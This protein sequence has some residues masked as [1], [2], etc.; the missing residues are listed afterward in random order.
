VKI[1]LDAAPEAASAHSPVEECTRD[2]HE[3]LNPEQHRAVH[4]GRGPVVLAAAAG[5]GKTTVVTLRVEQ[6][7][8]DGVDPTR[9]GAFTFGNDAAK[10]IE[11]RLHKLGVKTAKVSTIH[12]LCYEI[13]RM[14]GERWG[15]DF[16]LDEKHALHICLKEIIQRTLKAN[17]IDV[18][19]VQS[20]IGLAKA[21]GLSM[22]PDVALEYE[23]EVHKFFQ[24]H[25]KKH[26]RAGTYV[27]AYRLLEEQRITRG[28]LDFDDMLSLGALTLQKD[29]DV[30][31]NWQ[32]RFDYLIV[33]EAQDSSWIQ[34]WVAL[35]LAEPKNNI[36]LVGDCQQS[37]YRWRG[38]LP[39]EFVSFA[40]KFSVVR[41]PTNYR[42]TQEIC[43]CA[44]RLTHDQDWNVTGPTL[45]H[46]AAPSDPESAIAVEYGSPDDEAR[47]IALKIQALHEDGVRYGD[48]AILYRVTSL[49]VPVE[50]AFLKAQIPYRVWSG[51]NFYERKEV[52]DL[53][54]YLRVA[55]LRDPTEEWVKRTVNAPFRY[56]G[57][58]YVEN[59]ASFAQERGIAFL[60]ALTQFDP[61]RESQRRAASELYNIHRSANA[62]IA[63]KK[64]AAT[65]L[66]YILDASRYLGFL[67]KEEGD[68]TPDPDGGR[69]AHVHQLLR[70]AEAFPNVGVFL[71]YA[72]LMNEALKK[73]RHKRAEDVVALSSIHRFKG[74]ERKHIFGIGWVD[75]IMPH[76]AN[77]DEGEELRLAY[78]CLTRA[79]EKFEASWPRTEVS[80]RGVLEVRP[81][82]FIAKAGMPVRRQNPEQK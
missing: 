72:E 45:H 42:S 1:R 8:H 4:W 41:V 74:L 16:H 43:K 20:C 62:L 27:D 82:P 26:W 80:T 48:I 3:R 55:A 67:K 10:E 78:V 81:S 17:D 11:D 56:L 73:A 29:P 50:D 68:D 18:N 52:K 24:A 38:A 14:D 40:K 53:L 44:T 36:M 6:L 58:V 30:L 35:N 65:V 32:A 64:G 75:G 37:L 28:L 63:D 39:D 51:V 25:A 13:L 79:K 71:D 22:H 7:V 31:A 9:I 15:G 23:G 60:D 77:P 76:A 46:G 2:L 34:N 12:S 54:A 5:A 19:D 70:V 33:D 47:S 21:A 69:V 61:P 57:K 59:V 49:L 66:G